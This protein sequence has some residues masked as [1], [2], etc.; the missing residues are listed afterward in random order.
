MYNKS[1]EPFSQTSA[2]GRWCLNVAY[3]KIEVEQHGERFPVHEPCFTLEDTITKKVVWC[4]HGNWRIDDAHEFFVS[5]SGWSVIRFH[6]TSIYSRLLVISPEGRDVL[7]VGV[8]A[9]IRPYITEP[10]IKDGRWELWIDERVVHSTAGDLWTFEARFRFFENFDSLFFVCRTGW[11]RYLVIDIEGGFVLDEKDSRTASL[12]SSLRIGDGEW[13]LD[14]LHK[15]KENRQEL[16]LCLAAERSGEAPLPDHLATLWN[17]VFV[18]LLI[19]R[20]ERITAVAHLLEDLQSLSDP[21]GISFI[22]IA[23]IK[24]FASFFCDRFRKYVHLAML[25]TGGRPQGYALLYFNKVGD[26]PCREA[27]LLALPECVEKREDLIRSLPLEV[28]P[29]DV[30]FQLGAPDC[31]RDSS[32][33]RETCPHQDDFYFECWDYDEPD[34]DGTPVSW[35]LLWRRPKSPL[36]PEEKNMTMTEFLISLNSVE[37]EDSEDDSAAELMSIT[38]F[39]WND[40]YWLMREDNRPIC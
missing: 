11:G 18:A 12:F 4:R 27:H 20:Q 36:S 25:R 40:A 38:R 37:K 19:V 1:Y 34:Q 17:N 24:Q 29:K 7:T 5:D 23:P 15:T 6:G 31:I 16:E 10:P 30:A 35:G 26:W 32:K 3:Q 2:D 21:R 8:S 22:N 13:A 28:T 39:V 14:I 9:F 33:D